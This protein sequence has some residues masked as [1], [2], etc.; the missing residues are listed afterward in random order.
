MISTRKYSGKKG[1][2]AISLYP[3]NNSCEGES[4]RSLSDTAKQGISYAL[5]TCHGAWP[6]VTIYTEI[7]VFCPTVD[8]CKYCDFQSIFQGHEQT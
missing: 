6:M 3:V 5:S 4:F 8:S 1:R 2:P 7:A